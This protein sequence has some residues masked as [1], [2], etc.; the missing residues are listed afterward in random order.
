LDINTS[1]QFNTLLLYGETKSGKTREVGACAVHIYKRSGRKTRLY[2]TDGG[3][4]G[5]I[6]D[7]VDAGIVEAV[8][9]SSA[10]QTQIRMVQCSRGYW[11][12]SEGI[13]LPPEKQP[14][15][16]DVGCVAVEGLTSMAEAIMAECIREGRKIAEDVVGKFQL[17]DADSGE[18][19]NFGNPAQAHYGWAQS[20][21]RERLRDFQSLVAKGLERIVY[22]ALESLAEDKKTKQVV[23]GPQI[24]GGAMTA[25]IGQRVGDLIHMEIVEDPKTKKATYRAYFTPH[26]DP[27]FRR[28]WP[29]SLRLS[30]EANA[31]LK[32][33]AEFKE[34]WVEMTDEDG[35][36]RRGVTRLF[37]WR[38][39]LGKSAAAKLKALKDAVEAKKKGEAPVGEATVLTAEQL[40]EQK[41]KEEKFTRPVPSRIDLG[42]KK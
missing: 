21:M 16:K 35:I 4:W 31:A 7:L 36:L 40:L 17:T 38:E 20:Q 37:D 8:N 19:F 39:E 23:L 26:M 15:W 13:W 34:G 28:A 29:A 22:T 5:A 18:R 3:G 32:N 25:S 10:E 42:F 33:H 27:E 9:V 41:A 12:N 1:Q 30:P 24:I 2:C 6:Q 11:P 14:D